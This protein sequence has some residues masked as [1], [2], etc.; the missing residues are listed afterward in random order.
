MRI[1]Q[2]DKINVPKKVSKL[3][4]LGRNKEIFNARK[5]WKE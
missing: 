1:N 5:D 4:V 2:L 3:V